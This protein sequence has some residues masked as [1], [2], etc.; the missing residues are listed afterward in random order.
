MDIKNYR[1]KKNGREIMVDENALIEGIKAGHYEGN[2]EYKDLE[3]SSPW[4]KL[5]NDDV[6]RKYFKDRSGRV[7]SSSLD[8]AFIDEEEE[9]IANAT[10]EALSDLKPLRMGQLLDKTFFLFKNKFW[11]NFK[12]V[13]FVQVFV[14]LINQL[15]KFSSIHFLQDTNYDYNSLNLISSLPGI[16]LSSLAYLLISAAIIKATRA[17]IFGLDMKPGEAYSAGR[18]AIL[19]LFGTG[20]IAWFIV[21]GGFLLLIIPG[22]ILVFSYLMFQ[23]IVVLERKSGF[24]ALARSRKLMRTKFDKGMAGS[25][26]WRGFLLFLV[27]GFIVGTVGAFLIIP[28]TVF[29]AIAGLEGYFTAETT[30]E[31][32]KTQLAMAPFE[33]LENLGSSAVVPFLLIGLTVMYYDTRIRVEGF[34]LYIE[35]KRVH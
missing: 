26:S 19:P 33:L 14:Y 27:N 35:S 29:T 5:K 34:D 7:V 25:N 13:L 3:G 9:L 2:E 21:T 15:I 16:I 10:E 30:A 12:I 8:P 1:I 28:R 4:A 22:I 6:F 32:Y 31:L 11:R 23:V 24:K 17:Q 20:L 18:S